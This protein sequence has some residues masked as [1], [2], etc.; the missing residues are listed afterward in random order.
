MTQPRS[1]GQFPTH[2]SAI[3]RATHH[4]VTDGAHASGVVDI[5]ARRTRARVSAGALDA[6]VR[7]IRTQQ[8]GMEPLIERSWEILHQDPIPKLELGATACTLDGELALEADAERGRWLLPAF[9]AGLRSVA[10]EPDSRSADV[11]ALGQALA[12]LR[13]TPAMLGQFADW[14]WSDG[15]E[16]V[17]AELHTSFAEI[18]EVPDDPARHIA[19][20]RAVRSDMADALASAL[21]VTT[22]DLDAAAV[23]AEFQAPLDTFAQHSQAGNLALQPAEADALRV[24]SEESAFWVR[25]EIMLALAHPELRKSMSAKSLARQL[26]RVAGESFDQ[27]LALC[28]ALASHPDPYAKS[29]ITALEDE[30][31]G[32]EIA[33]R[34]ALD[35]QGAIQLSQVIRGQSHKLAAGVVHGLIERAHREGPVAEQFVV[36]MAGVVGEQVWCGHLEPTLVSVGARSTMARIAAQAHTSAAQM[37]KILAVLQPGEAIALLPH[38]SADLV[39]ALEETF[40]QFVPTA[41][42]RDRAVLVTHLLARNHVTTTRRLVA[43]VLDAKGEGW[44]LRTV[45]LVAQAG[46]SAGLGDQVIQ[47]QRNSAVPL[48]IR[49]ALLEA[50]VATQA[51][52]ENALKWRASELLDAPEIRERLAELRRARKG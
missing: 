1:S 19:E 41:S 34:V 28:S 18:L 45:R 49:L 30:P 9:M 7:A 24:R 4:G 35:R 51:T 36:R 23:L 48:G 26:V 8:P 11:V 12:S 47:L 27:F 5:G 21:R 52:A 25:Q 29:V 39:S 33:S 37:A 15:L 17:R 14:I 38:L 32:E 50:L 42:V 44:D 6:L 16:G 43:A 31:V 22:N 3:F 46:I 13:C 2:D 10:V 20:I 40:L